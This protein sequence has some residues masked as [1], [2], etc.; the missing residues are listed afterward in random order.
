MSFD[1][2]LAADF[3]YS[4]NALL[5]LLTTGGPPGTCEPEA[6]PPTWDVEDEPESEPS[7]IDDLFMEWDD[8]DSEGSGL[9]DCDAD[10]DGSGYYDVDSESDPETAPTP[11]RLR[12]V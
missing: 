4:Y 3:P 8:T 6:K 9:Y 10:S 5:E 2:L 11:K 7:C 12:I 1:A